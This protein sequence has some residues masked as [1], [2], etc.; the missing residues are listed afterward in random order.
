MDRA[1][2]FMPD[3]QDLRCSALSCSEHR[4]R[5]YDCTISAEPRVSSRGDAH[6]RS[7]FEERTATRDQLPSVRRRDLAPN[8]A[9]GRRT[10]PARLQTPV[11]QHLHC[12]APCDDPLALPPQYGQ[13]VRRRRRFARSDG[14]LARLLEARRLQSNCHLRTACN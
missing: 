10:K 8:V 9:G 4:S 5:W 2:R 11:E 6:A 7:R 13:L 3:S 12:Q 14:P 1:H